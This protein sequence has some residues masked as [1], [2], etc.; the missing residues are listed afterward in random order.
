MQNETT[1]KVAGR[2][3][4]E[5]KE[6]FIYIQD[7]HTNTHV[8]MCVYLEKVLWLELYHTRTSIDLLFLCICFSHVPT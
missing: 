4:K 5:T 3:K 8:T 7:T 6:D 2:E 1:R